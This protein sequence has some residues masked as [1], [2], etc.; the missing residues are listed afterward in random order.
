MGKCLALLH[1]N[2]RRGLITPGGAVGPG[3]LRGAAERDLQ[4]LE[5]LKDFRRLFH[6]ARRP[7]RVSSETV[8]GCMSAI[9]PRALPSPSFVP[10]SL[11]WRARAREC[12]LAASR[13][14]Q[15]FARE[16]MLKAAETFD[17][18]AREVRERE[19]AGGVS[20]IGELVWELYRA[21]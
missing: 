15:D 7:E 12:R 11:R 18:N 8:R 1:C 4:G 19:I 13:M 9:A 14:R 20:R 5:I 16:R 6:D 21:R 17:R 2:K 3:I 10:E